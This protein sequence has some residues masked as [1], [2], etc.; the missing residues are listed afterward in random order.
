MS[1][2][3]S[4]SLLYM[5]VLSFDSTFIAYLKSETDY[6]DA[7]I[8][9]MRALCVATGLVGTALGP[10]LE[11]SLGLVRAGTWSLWL[12]LFP[13]TL[14]VAALFTYSP[15][16][17]AALGGAKPRPP[18]WNTALL[19]LG[20]ALSRIGLWSFDLCQLAQGRLPLECR[21]FTPPTLLI[22]SQF[23]ML[24]AITR[25]ATLCKASNLDCRT[26]SIWYASR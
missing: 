1:A 26:C 16:H 24:L 9:G 25:D 3:I 8:A 10:Y 2:S 7:F 18:A 5:S 20:L 19:F 4:I 11:R 23:N 22:L 21:F 12:E 17:S 14:C 13:L 6:S 15:D